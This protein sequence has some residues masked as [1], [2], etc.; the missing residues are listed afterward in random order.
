MVREENGS[1]Q[2]VFE[3]VVAVSF[4]LVFVV[5]FSPVLLYFLIIHVPVSAFK[6]YRFLKRN[7][8]KRILCVSTGRKFQTWWADYRKEVLELGIDDVVV[9]DSKTGDNEYDNFKWDKMISRDAGFP[10]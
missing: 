6:K 2:N 8:D 7:A 5:L 10:V 3:C 9:F 1:L 4:L